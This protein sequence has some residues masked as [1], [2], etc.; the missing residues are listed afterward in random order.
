[1]VLIIRERLFAFRPRLRLVRPCLRLAGLE[2][3]QGLLKMGM[4]WHVP[5]GIS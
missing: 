5:R 1:M 2:T 3:M 4:F